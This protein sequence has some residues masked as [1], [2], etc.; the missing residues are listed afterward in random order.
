MDKL[1]MQLAMKRSFQ[2]FKDLG[3]SIS[4]KL[5]KAVSKIFAL[6]VIEAEGI[7]AAK[8]H[9]GDK[10]YDFG[11]VSRAKVTTE[12]VNYLVDILQTDATTIGDF[13]YQISGTGV[14]TESNTDVSLGTAIGTARTTG[15]QVEGASANIYRSVATISYTAGAAVTEH[16]IFNAAY[17]SGQDDGILLDRSV[18]AAINVV[19]GDSIEF[20]YELTVNA[21]A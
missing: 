10:V 16:A 2:P 5:R 19:S 11:V 9:R 21:E 3:W 13:K 12:F 20:T 8:L 7:L 15:T 17:A 18:F 1:A 4:K 6:H 14:G